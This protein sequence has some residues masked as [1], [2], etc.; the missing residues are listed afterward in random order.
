MYSSLST[1]VSLHNMPDLHI[2]A[3]RLRPFMQEKYLFPNKY[4]SILC[5]LLLNQMFDSVYSQDGLFVTSKII[6]ETWSFHSF[7]F[8]TAHPTIKTLF[9]PLSTYLTCSLFCPVPS[10]P[11]TKQR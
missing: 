9:H 3:A 10:Q 6:V 4:A 8:L 5:V 11:I 1:A 7:L 2:M